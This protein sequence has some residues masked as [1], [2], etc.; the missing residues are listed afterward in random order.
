MKSYFAVVNDND[1]TPRRRLLGALRE[2]GLKG[3]VNIVKP[4]RDRLQGVAASPMSPYDRSVDANY[5][6]VDICDAGY[7]GKTSTSDIPSAYR[8]FF[9]ESIRSLGPTASLVPSSRY[10]AN[11]LLRPIDFRRACTIVELGPGTGAVTREILKRLRPDGKLLAI[12]INQTFISHLRM[13]SDDRRLIP[14]RGN[15]TDLVPLLARH[16]V[17]PV[18]AVVSSLGLTG[19]DDTTRMFIMGQIGSCLVSDGIMTQY[20][21]VHAYPGHLDIQKLRF[22]RFNEAR[23]LRNFFGDVSVGRVFLNFPPALIFTCRR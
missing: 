1:G 6:A 10:L 14:L 21:Y 9:H 22:H 20:Q 17:G 11:A 4:F 12:D 7:R 8:L 19:M 15:A 18:D 23:F 16:N 3:R 2:L 5:E 13:V